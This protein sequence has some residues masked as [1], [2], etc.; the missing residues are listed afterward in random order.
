MADKNKSIVEKTKDWCGKF[1]HD[2]SEAGLYFDSKKGREGLGGLAVA[3]GLLRTAT[4]GAL[5]LAAVNILEPSE[6][7]QVAISWMPAMAFAGVNVQEIYEYCKTKSKGVDEHKFEDKPRV[8]NSEYIQA[9]DSVIDNSVDT[10]NR[11]RAKTI[12][13]NV[14]TINSNRAN[15]AESLGKEL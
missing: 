3:R 14:D 8:Q 6:A 10:I 12:K 15:I 13:N 11:N 7:Y 1:V 9:I 4:V 2:W 5:T